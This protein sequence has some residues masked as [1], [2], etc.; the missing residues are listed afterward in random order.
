MRVTFFVST[1]G[2][3]SQSPADGRGRNAPVVGVVSRLR[4]H[5]AR[6][7]SPPQCQPT[8]TAATD[9]ARTGRSS[10]DRPAP[11]HL[12]GLRESWPPEAA[13]A[14]VHLQP[15]GVDSHHSGGRRGERRRHGG[16]WQRRQRQSGQLATPASPQA[17][18]FQVQLTSQD[19]VVNVSKGFQNQLMLLLLFPITL[20]LSEL[21]RLFLLCQAA[22]VI[23]LKRVRR[24]G[25]VHATP[26]PAWEVDFRG[27]HGC[28][29]PTTDFAAVQPASSG[30]SREPEYFQPARLHRQ[31]E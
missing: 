1:T 15:S 20:K 23:C 16:C 26:V 24:I 18:R 9:G 10:A 6:H 22:R 12:V 5:L 7:P 8:A 21:K 13:A 17:F 4:V 29:P 31:Q 3:H 14:T 28:R 11:H 2:Q 30:W 25:S 27:H 19:K